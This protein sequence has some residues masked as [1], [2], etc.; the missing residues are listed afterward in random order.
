MDTQFNQFEP[1]AVVVQDDHIVAVGNENKILT[2]YS[3]DNTINCNGK[4]LMPGLVNAHTHVPMSLMRGLADDL[5]LDVWLLGHMMPVEREFVSPEFVHLGTL[6]SAAELIRSGVTTFADMYYFEDEV[7]KATVQAGLRSIVGETVL[8]FTAPDAPSYEEGL[9]YAED[10]I[11]RWKNHPLIIP[12]IAPHAPYTCTEEILQSASQLAQKYDVPLHI[13]LA[14]TKQEVENM[15]NEYGMP[16]IPFVRK[17]GVFDAKVIAAHCIYLD[18]GEMRTLKNYNVGVIHNPSSNLKLASGFAQVAKMLEMGITVGIGT[19]GP[20]SNN[21]LDMFEE[22]RLTSFIAKG[23]TG[24]PTVVPARQVLTMATRMGAQALHLGKEIGSLEPGK[25]ADLILIDTS[26]VHNAPRYQRDSKMVYAQLVYASKAPDV[27][28]VMVNG[29]FLMRD[30]Q[31]LTLDEKDLMAQAQDYAHKIDIFLMEREK[32]VLSKLIAIETATEEESFEVQI[33]VPVKDPQVVLDAINSPEI[34]I[35][36]K[37]HYREYDT[38]FFFDDPQQGRLR[39]R[40]DEY[41]DENN[42][43]VKVRYRLTLLGPAHEREFAHTVL[44]SRSRYLAPATH[45]L[46]FYREYFNPSKE[47]VI[48]KERLRWKILFKET[49][50]YINLDHVTVPAM[51]DFLEVKSRT[52]SRHDAEEK[53]AL[54]PDLLRSL[55]LG[56]VEA[57][58]K[59]YSDLA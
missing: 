57:I 19:D 23:I 21:D 55:G 17:Q 13:H 50:F 52:W 48:E 20:A 47:L 44:L 43:I 26:L 16:V 30:R 3:A 58:G 40:E 15:R 5:R 24:N 25:K 39:Y 31:L 59:D 9:A 33:K 41:I 49:E 14:E 6:L 22:M 56:D 12:A 53:A 36:Y 42:K 34:T 10:F 2:S 8:K 46:R 45:S 1:G 37:R 51:G 32:S 4:V 35:L 54:M 18:E 7:A 28:D 38:Y 11:K 27:T 29:K